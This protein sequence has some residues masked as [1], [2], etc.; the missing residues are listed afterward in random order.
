MLNQKRSITVR[1]LEILPGLLTWVTLLGA[2]FLS[3]YHPAWIS[4]YIILFDLYWFL[5]GANVAIH[6]LH[7]YSKLST[8]KQISWIEWCAKLA[9]IENLKSFFRAQAQSAKT[10]PLRNLYK[11]HLVRLESIKDNRN[12]D[13]TRIYHLIIIPLYKESLE[14]LVP[15]INSFI[16]ADYPL[17][18]L[19]LVLAVEER[20]GREALER[21]EILKQKFGDKFFSQ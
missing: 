5:K 15:T 19:I 3:Y 2:P 1:L 7:S 11:D 8:H 12:L 14:I 9:D 18:K 20:A 13:W 4:A 16:A 6:L 21:A 10:R 17:D